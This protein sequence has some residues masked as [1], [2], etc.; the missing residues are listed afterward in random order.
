MLLILFLLCTWLPI[1]GLASMESCPKPTT[2]SL[3][4]AV[5]NKHLSS[6]S[7]TV[8][9]VASSE[10]LIPYSRDSLII[11]MLGSPCLE[12][13]YSGTTMNESMLLIIYGTCEFMQLF[14]FVSYAPTPGSCSNAEIAFVNRSPIKN[15][16]PIIAAETVSMTFGQA[17]NATY[18][19]VYG[20]EVAF[21][22]YLLRFVSTRAWDG[23]YEQLNNTSDEFK[24]PRCDCRNKTKGQNK[25]SFEWYQ[26]CPRDLERKEDNFLFIVVCVAVG[27]ALLLTVC[28]SILT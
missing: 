26:R 3:M 23:K 8:Y 7:L 28:C 11:A 12:I 19:E 10:G 14:R 18:G 16:K 15:C 20:L 9:K 17:F 25:L 2:Q 1:P 24:I 4:S 13:H 5:N 27:T 6:E 22:E 21:S